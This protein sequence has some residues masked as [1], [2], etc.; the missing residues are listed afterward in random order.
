MHGKTGAHMKEKKNSTTARLRRFL[1]AIL[2]AGSLIAAGWSAT[3]QAQSVNF[4]AAPVARSGTKVSVRELQIPGKA[5]DEFNRGLRSLEKRELAKSLRHFDAA[6]RVFPEYYEVYYHEGIAA[7]IER[8]NE[9]ALRCFQKAMD[10]S[11]NGYP[12]AEFGYGLALLREGKAKEAE[13]VVR[14]G[15]ESD[16][17]NADGHVVLGFVLLKLNR[18]DE[19]EKSAREAL[20]VNAPNSAK[21]YLVLSDLNAERGNYADQARD[22]DTYLKLRPNDPNKSALQ[23]VR[24]LAKRLAARSQLTA[25]N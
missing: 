14:H 25:K 7:L 5:R 24:D 9:E 8:N 19:A 18:P 4:T 23:S 17:N 20:D 15:I 12:P 1:R 13:R 2:F 10:V 21:G 6:L 11:D 3:T 22:L 16:S